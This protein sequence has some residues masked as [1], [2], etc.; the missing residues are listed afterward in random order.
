MKTTSYLCTWIGK[1]ND[2]ETVASHIIFSI[3][4]SLTKIILKDLPSAAGVGTGEPES[5]TLTTGQAAR[6]QG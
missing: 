1:H 2:K 5:G 4:Y 6:T 3:T